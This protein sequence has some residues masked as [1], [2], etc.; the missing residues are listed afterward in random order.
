MTAVAAI[1]T[2]TSGTGKATT[3]A[4]LVGRIPAKIL[5]SHVLPD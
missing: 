3:S 5:P 1:S 4:A 2:F